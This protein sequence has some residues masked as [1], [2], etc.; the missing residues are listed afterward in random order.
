[1][2][3]TGSKSK[4]TTTSR[5]SIRIPSGQSLH[6]EQ[7]SLAE[8]NKAVEGV[9]EVALTLEGPIVVAAPAEEIAAWDGAELLQLQGIALH[10]GDCISVCEGSEGVGYIARIPKEVA[11]AIE[12]WQK[13]GKRVELHTP[14]REAVEV[15]VAARR[16]DKNVVLILEDGCCYAAY[17]ERHRLLYAEV[18]PLANEAALVNLLALLNKDFELR[19]ARFELRGEESRQ[20][21]KCVRSY[22]GRVKLVK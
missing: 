10:E 8:W 15:A 9:E 14:L 5:L 22:F 18:L 16:R 3:V 17:A 11:A 2:Q 20:Y 1:M 7:P 19:R 6:R 13:E 4:S 12:S 21:Y